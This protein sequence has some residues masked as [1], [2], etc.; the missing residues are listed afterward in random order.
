MADLSTTV[1]KQ[2]WFI[3]PNTTIGISYIWR[4]LDQNS[5]RYLPNTTPEFATSPTISPEGFPDGHEWEL[6][7]YVNINLGK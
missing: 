4:S 3:L 5:P 2:D 6:R 1:G 7:T